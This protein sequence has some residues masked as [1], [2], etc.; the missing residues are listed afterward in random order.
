MK[1]YRILDE[2]GYVCLKVELS[3][4]EAIQLLLGKPFVLRDI[5]LP[6]ERVFVCMK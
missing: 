6:G 5:I 3:V 4:K 2:N 1:S